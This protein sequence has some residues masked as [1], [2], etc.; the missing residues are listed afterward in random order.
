MSQKKYRIIVSGGGTGGHIFPAIAIADALKQSGIAEDILFV[1][2]Q[3]RMEMEKVPAAGYAIEGLEIAG[4]QRSLTLKNL[5]VPFKIVKSLL[6]ARKI[7]KKFKPDIAIGVGG[8]ASGPMLFAAA[9]QGVPTV[10]QEQNSYPGVTNKILSKKAQ[11]IFVAYSGMESFFPKDKII[12][13][14]N[15]VRSV[16]ANSLPSKE[17]SCEYF[18]LDPK[19][20]VVL[21]FGGSLGALT[22]N[23]SIEQSLSQFAEKDIQLIWQTGSYYHKN[24]HDKWENSTPNGVKIVEFLQNMHYAYGAADLIISRAGALSISELCIVGKPTILVPSPNVSEDHQTKNAMALVEKQAA[25]YV[26]DS[27]ARNTLGQV[28]FDTLKDTQLL[29]SLSKN[30]KALAKPTATESIVESIKN[31]LNKA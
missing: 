23:D 31:L 21:S 8:Y 5:K 29:D 11:K 16:I 2:A 28:I 7:I 10:I 19:K 15:P 27:E 1:G 17:E 12:H 26:K 24:I 18:G 4:I 3:G 9:S 22:L 6:R 25:I 20:L 14:G 13:T 30:I